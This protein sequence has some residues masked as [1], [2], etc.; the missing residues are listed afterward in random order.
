[1]T[2]LVLRA[3]GIGDLVA[4]VPS[5]RGL[6]RAMPLQRIV[7]AAPEW[8]IPL[9]A[10]TGAVNAVTPL[11]GVAGLDGSA[12]IPV[13][14]PVTVSVN[15]H[16]RGPQSHRLLASVGADI[17]WGFRCPE[18]GVE[19]GPQWLDEEHEVSRW[20]RM[21]RWYGV[22][23][24]P[25]DL[26]LLP[27]SRPARWRAP[28]V[29]LHPGA[30]SP[31]RRWPAARFGVVARSLAEAGYEVV[32]TG[33]AGERRLASRIARQANLPAPAV[34]AGRTDVGQLAGLVA[35]AS[36]VIC[37][38][39]GVSHLATAFGTPSVVLFATA[40]PH[41]WGPPPDR[42][43]HQPLWHPGAGL[44]DISAQEVL[45]AA[46]RAWAAAKPTSAVS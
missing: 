44:L 27:P 32:I 4:A 28:T 22:D 6:R 19:V 9:V 12:R 43:R 45:T 41:L 46:E 34:L 21:L 7:L 13:R 42:P 26:A 30:K 39:T 1:M 14:T 23:S 37:G 25:N 10:L 33:S 29:I 20:C 15:L 18:A 2:V 5:L 24:D 16:G 40:G 3:L 8:L 17:Q 11:D 36:L 38:D 35:G 31:G